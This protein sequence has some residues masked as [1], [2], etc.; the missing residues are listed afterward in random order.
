LKTGD[1]MDVE[2]V[3]Y[4]EIKRRLGH[5]VVH[6]LKIDIEGFEWRSLEYM[7]E[8]GLLDGV[9]QLSMEIHTKDIKYIPQDRVVGKLLEFWKTLR[10]LERIG[11]QRVFYRNNLVLESVYYIPDKPGKVLATAVELLYLRK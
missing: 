2:M 8:R 9:Q 4:D 6:Y 7:F 3:T 5:N 1:K 11:F 10:I